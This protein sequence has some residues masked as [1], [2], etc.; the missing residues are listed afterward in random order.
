M[1][2]THTIRDN[3]TLIS[4]WNCPKCYK[5]F[6]DLNG[7]KTKNLKIRLHKNKCEKTE[8][9]TPEEIESR[10]R[11]HYNHIANNTEGFLF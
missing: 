1:P 8:T 6:D 9:M 7:L 11:K 5:L 10:N 3:S 4:T 2:F